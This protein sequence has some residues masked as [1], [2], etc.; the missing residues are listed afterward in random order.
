[1][2]SEKVLILIHLLNVFFVNLAFNKT[3]GIFFLYIFKNIPGHIS[4]SIKTA[5]LGFQYFKNLLTRNN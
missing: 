3:R 1:M 2:L 4:D 5:K